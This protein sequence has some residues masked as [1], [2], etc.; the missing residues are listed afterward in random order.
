MSELYSVSVVRV[1]ADTVDLDVTVVHPDA[2]GVPDDCTFALRMLWDPIDEYSYGKE[3]A[4]KNSPLAKEMDLDAYLNE[5]FI[6]ENAQGFIKSVRYV[7][8][9]NHPPPYWGDEGDE[10]F[11]DSDQR[12]SA[13]IRIQVTHPGW[14]SHMRVGMS[15]DTAGYGTGDGEPWDER[16]TRYP[17]DYIEQ[18]SDDPMAGMRQDKVSDKNKNMFEDAQVTEYILPTFGAKQYTTNDQ[19]LRGEAIT[20]ERVRA[21]L[22]Q[23]VLAQGRYRLEIGTLINVNDQGWLSIYHEASGGGS[24]GSSGASLDEIEYIGRAW[25]VER[26]PVDEVE[27]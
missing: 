5:D 19:E 7:S 20:I 27:V 26:I 23:P 1:E 12:S 3:P 24:Y 21:L 8:E 16:P 13:V 10:E 14:I 18:I 11:W 17:G 9:E 22:G 6:D 25:Y 2:G 4:V 15:W